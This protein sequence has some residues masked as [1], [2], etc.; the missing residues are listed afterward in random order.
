[1]KV[2]H[3]SCRVW[4]GPIVKVYLVQFVTRSLAS[5]YAAH[6]A[7]IQLENAS[8]TLAGGR[9]SGGNLRSKPSDLHVNKSPKNP[10]PYAAVKGPPSQRRPNADASPFGHI[11]SRYSTAPYMNRDAIISP[12]NLVLGRGRRISH[13]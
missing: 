10:L 7:C 5:A 3:G 6:T 13:T 11:D 4:N 1:M 9:A 12:A 8:A 2:M